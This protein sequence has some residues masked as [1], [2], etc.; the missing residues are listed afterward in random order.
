M[1][2]IK[3]PECGED[4]SNKAAV[5][6]HCG[7][8][9][10]EMD[11][12]DCCI[13]DGVSHNLSNIKSRLLNANLDDKEETNQIVYDLGS[14]IGS[15]SLRAAA[16]LARIILKTREVPETYNGS[17]LTHQSKKDDGKLHCPKCD[18]TNITTG[19]RGYNIVWGFIGSGKTVNRCGKCGY[20]WEPKK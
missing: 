20:K 4:V 8:P 15:I 19:S 14:Q 7:F 5:C 1:A 6:I 11:S 3:C 16:E 10:N 18:S 2:L 17:H 9:I 13:I 12:K